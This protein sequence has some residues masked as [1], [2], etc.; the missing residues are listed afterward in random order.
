MAQLVNWGSDPEIWKSLFS[1]TVTGLW[2]TFYLQQALRGRLLGS[3]H[4]SAG[5]RTCFLCSTSK[6]DTSSVLF[7]SKRCDVGVYQF[8]GV[9]FSFT[10]GFE[11]AVHNTHSDFSNQTLFFVYQVLLV[12]PLVGGSLGFLAIH[13]SSPHAPPTQNNQIVTK[14]KKK[15]LTHAIDVISPTSYITVH[16]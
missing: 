16:L 3:Y 7:D 4:N 12:K 6:H 1:D 15:L 11:G 10:F 8:W 14:V 13:L 5:A 9:R 2:S